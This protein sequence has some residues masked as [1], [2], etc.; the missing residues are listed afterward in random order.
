MKAIRVYEQGGP[1]VLRYED[2]PDLSPGP[3][4]VVIRQSAIGV[5]FADIYNR[6][7]LYSATLPYTPGGEG[8]GTVAALGTGV[9]E[10]KVGDLV[11]YTGV[12]SA[13]AEQA[14]GDATR[15]IKLPPDIDPA[16][17][18]AMLSQGTTAHYLSHSAYPLKAGDRCLIHAGAGGV[19]ALLIQMAKRLGAYVFATVSTEQKAAVA[20]EAGADDVILY[21]RD[22][23]AE[24]VKL[25][26]GGKGVH[27][28]YDAVGQT[29]FDQSIAC[30]MPRGY[31]VL[32][33]QSSGPVPPISPAVLQRGSYFLTRPTAGPYNASEEERQWR[34]NDVCAWVRS[35][36]LKVRIFG[37]FPL[38]EAVAAHRALEGRETIGKVLLVP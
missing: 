15:I 3:G 14:L 21:T 1:E 25:S 29:T 9:T 32:Y 11:A 27:V 16:T 24:A 13:Y 38:Q 6:S 35:G 36:E 37:T 34:L 7:G 2:V 10:L 19:G 28:V 12:P 30:L 26:T 5:N 18:A 31:M 22:D 4:Q 23:F 20:R 8:A 17:G 33:G